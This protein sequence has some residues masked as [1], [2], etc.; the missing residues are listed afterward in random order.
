MSV[1][2]KG[3]VPARTSILVLISL[4]AILLSS[5]ALVRPSLT[6]GFTAGDNGHPTSGPYSDLKGGTA[7]FSFKTD[8]ATL[9]CTGDNPNSFSF[10][11]D[12]GVDR[13][14]PRRCHAG[15]LSVA[16]PGCHQR[17][18]RGR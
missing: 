10:K 15:G 5:M 18:R 3:Q 14:A 9:T 1:T 6:L 7:E 12:Y 4:L 16:Q 8:T 17:Q 11:I 13:H 2:G